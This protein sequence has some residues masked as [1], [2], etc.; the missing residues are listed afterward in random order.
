M[1]N[2]PRRPR[3]QPRPIRV[4]AIH[5]FSAQRSSEL[6]L[7]PGDEIVVCEINEIGWTFGRCLANGRSGWFPITYTEDVGV[8]MTLERL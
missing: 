8:E 4:K 5:A 2:T 3:L 7:S 1:S 6:S